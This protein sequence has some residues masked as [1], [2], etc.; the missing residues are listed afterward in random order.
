MLLDLPSASP[1]Q[2]GQEWVSGWT[3]NFSSPLFL[4]SLKL[5]CTK[6]TADYM[7]FMTKAGTCMAACTSDDPEYFNAEFAGAC[8]WYAQHSGDTC[9][10]DTTAAQTTITA[11][12]TTTAT[13]TI[14]TDTVRTT[15]IT[16]AAGTTTATV[17]SIASTG[18]SALPSGVSLASNALSIISVPA[19]ASSTSA[20]NGAS[21]ATSASTPVG[22]Q[23]GNAAGTLQFSSYA[24]A[25]V[26]GADFLTF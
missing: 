9:A 26:A 19:S 4:D 11:V 15:T 2:A 7:P 23:S 17:N 16:A 10:S 6:Y 21:P 3:M 20:S 24:I 25:L 1:I 18:F 5:M 22:E 13:Q 12:Q 14:I 8:A